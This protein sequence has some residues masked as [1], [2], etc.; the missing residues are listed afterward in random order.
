MNYIA[1]LL[2]IVMKSEESVFWALV[3]IVSTYL[4]EYF[5]RSLIG[6]IVDIK[7]GGRCVC[8]CVCIFYVL[9]FVCKN[10][11]KMFAETDPFMAGV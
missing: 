5:S 3:A 8:V 7:V 1:G 10:N 2:L 9:K 11:M 4:E 6:S